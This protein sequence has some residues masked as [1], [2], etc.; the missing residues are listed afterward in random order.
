MIGT[1]VDTIKSMLT[2]ADKQPMHIGETNT[3]WIYLAGLQLAKASV[4]IALNTTKD[5]ELSNILN[6]DLQLNFKQ[7]ETLK[8]LL[9]REG[10]PLPPGHEDMPKSNA[11]SIPLGAK[12]TDE[13]IANELSIKITSLIMCAAGGACESVRT[14]LGAMF[15]QFLGEKM[16]LGT[17]LKQLMRYRGWIKVPPF[18]VPPGA[19]ITEQQ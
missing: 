8:D 3:C 16:L 14:D 4:Q 5:D 11:E 15:A 18:Y 6:E 12:M 2:E 17:R 7:Q 13:I 10:I 9:I 19:P 1:A